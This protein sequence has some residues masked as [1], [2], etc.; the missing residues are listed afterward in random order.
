MRKCIII[1]LAI[2]IICCFVTQAKS[3][4]KKKSNAKQMFE[5]GK[6]RKAILRKIKNKMVS[7]SFEDVEIEDAITAL[8]RMGDIKI[9][10]SKYA[11]IDQEILEPRLV[12]LNVKR[13]KLIRALDKIIE[14]QKDLAWHI[15]DGRIV[16]DRKEIFVIRR[17]PRWWMHKLKYS[18]DTGA[19]KAYFANHHNTKAIPVLI[20]QINCRKKPVRLF[21]MAMLQY[22]YRKMKQKHYKTAVPKLIKALQD[23]DAEI[24]IAAAETLALLRAQSAVPMLMKTLEDEVDE[25]RVNEPHN[26]AA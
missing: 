1:I 4:A 11:N 7:F 21:V 17:S 25:V 23:K 6:Q 22:K 10:L 26:K 2:C 9:V 18:E 16:I 5:K 14:L 12:K 13:I 19:A 24:R 8:M 20:K 15:E 3:K